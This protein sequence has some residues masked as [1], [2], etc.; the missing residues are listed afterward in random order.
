MVP[1]KAQGVQQFLL[2]DGIFAAQEVAEQLG[3]LGGK[4]LPVAAGATDGGPGGA[5]LDAVAAGEEHLE[6]VEPGAEGL[7]LEPAE[8]GQLFVVQH[9]LGVG[10]G[11]DLLDPGGQFL[12]GDGG[13]LQYQAHPLGGFAPAEGDDDTLAGGQIETG[14]DQVVV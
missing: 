5:G 4:G 9:R 14:G 7:G 3:G 2:G 1:A 13:D 6:G 11:L 12:R 10:G 8:E